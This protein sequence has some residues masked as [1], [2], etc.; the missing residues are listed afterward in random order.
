MLQ[1]VQGTTTTQTTI[2]TSTYTDTSLTA[3]ITPSATASNVLIMVSQ[4]VYL[5]RNT[6]AKVDAGIR[7]VR[8]ST[9]IGSFAGNISGSMMNAALNGGAN[10][11]TTWVS[12][13]YLDSP[14]TTSSTTYKTQ[15]QSANTT[16]GAQQD[17]I[18]STIT[19]F[20]IGA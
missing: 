17:S 9:V 1:V 13:A 12:F 15:M 11:L 16:I 14:S 10:E 6:T 5:Y 7:L 3:S 8:G 2:A 19:L 20:E 18:M 4:L